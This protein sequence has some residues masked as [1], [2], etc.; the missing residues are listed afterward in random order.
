MLQSFHD[1]DGTAYLARAVSYKRKM[2]M[3]LTSVLLRQD[4]EELPEVRR[5]PTIPDKK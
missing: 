5:S 1:M 2:F 4:Q 3:K